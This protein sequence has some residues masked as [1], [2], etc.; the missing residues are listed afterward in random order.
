MNNNACYRKWSLRGFFSARLMILAAQVLVTGSAFAQSGNEVFLIDKDGF[1]VMVQ[2]GGEGAAAPI[3][4]NSDGQ[5]LTSGHVDCTSVP[6]H[7]QCRTLMYLQGVDRDKQEQA[8]GVVIVTKP[9]ALLLTNVQ[10]SVHPPP[11]IFVDGEVVNCYALIG[12]FD[13]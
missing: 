6:N 1:F 12:S 8:P 7:P 13:C 4:L 10:S 5:I 11:V 3:V 9:G 2:A